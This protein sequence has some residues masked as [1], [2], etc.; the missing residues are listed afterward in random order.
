MA[1]IQEFSQDT[2]FTNPELPTDTLSSKQ[3]NTLVEVVGEGE[4][5][6]S[7]TASKAGLT[8]GT[9]AYN[10]CFK[11]DI[12]LNGTQLLLSSAS[13]TAPAEGDFNF[14][15]VGFE[16]R[17]GTSDQTFINGIANIETETSVGVA[18]TFGNPI[19]RAVSNNSVNAIRVTVSFTNIQKVEDNGEITGAS[20]GVKIEIIQND[21]T[22]TTPIDDTVTGRSTSSYF[23]DYLINLPANTSFPINVRVSRTTADTTSPEFTAFSWSSMTEVIFKQNAYPDTAHLALRFSAESFPRIPKRSFRLRGIKTKI[24]HNATVDIATGRITYTGT[25]NGT[26]KTD[27]EWHSDPAWVLWDILTNTRYGLSVAE[28]SLDQYTFYNQSVY[29]NELVDDGEG[30]QEARFAINV[31]ITQQREAFNLINDICSVMRVMPF[32]AAG[33][34][35]ISG[36]RPSDPVYQFTLANVTEEGFSYSGSSLKTRHTVI[37]VGYFDLETRAIDYETVEDTAAIAKYGTVIKTIKT[38]GCTSRGQAS[39]MGKWFLYNEQKSGES[40]TFKITPE[41]GTL[42]RCGQIISISDPVK[43]GLRRGGKIKSATTTAIVVDDS[44]NTD[45]DATNNAT[46]SVILPDGSLETKTISSI[47]GTIINVSSAFSAAPNP[48]SVFVIQND[49]LETT[50]WRVITVKENSDFT[51][52]VTALAHDSAKY[53]FVEDGVALPTRT[54]TVLTSIKDAPSNLEAE[55]K[56]VVID[57]KA[58]SK[59]FLNWQPVLGVNKYQVQYRFNNGN[60]ITQ[61]VMSNTFDI[62]NSQKGIYEVRVFSFNAIDKPSAEPAIIT[63]NAL[64]KTALPED[65]Q[66][67]TIEPYNDDF[68]KLRFDKATSL[69]VVHGGSV[70]VRHSNLTDG[71]GTFTNSVDLIA[72]L[73]GNISETLIPAIEGEVIL[74]FRDDGGRLSNGETSVIVSPPN[75]QPTLA[76]FTDRED[77]D[78]PPFG[79]AKVNTFFD[80]TLGALTLAS[81]TTIDEVTALIDTLSQIDFLGDV[82]PTGT[83]EFA[84]PL[85]LGSTMDTKLTRH[86]VTESIYANSFIDQR[87]ALI[88]TWND[89]DQL[90]AFETNANLLVATTTQD[91]AL[92]TSGT[93]AQSGTTITITKSS[94]GYSVG[95]FVVVDF[96]SGNG[97]DGNYEIKTVPNANTF[98]LTASAS[99]TTSGN[100]TYG[101]EFGSFNTFTNGVLRGRGFK[102]KVNLSSN[103]PAQTILIKQLGYTATLNRRVETVNSVIASGTST[104]AVTFQDKFFTGFSGTDVA[105][106]AAKPTI[107]IVIENA[108]SGDFFSLSSIS[109]TGF[110]IDIKNGSS[111]VD[112]NFKYTAVG[113][114]RGS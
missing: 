4:I 15:D 57:N 113:F 10:T 61:N 48:N 99:Q 44:T 62:E 58:V 13:N 22:T 114:G 104:K 46:L 78:S 54:T 75:T 53:A 29:N 56:I 84:N 34:I 112:R 26:F 69:D 67:L 100:C 6:G 68:V 39:R 90:T 16:P 108:Q 55:E 66:N 97:V 32:Y 109:S 96:T 28:S 111:F 74:K 89:I 88:D 7:A 93:Y 107:G 73:S 63:V 105:A 85:D 38:F 64:G 79:G 8:K 60:F 19:T 71:T 27:K 94:H 14:K 31:N 12:F 36:D 65:V 81:T 18:V 80:S 20:A 33:S 92:S 37:N 95:S 87:T 35:S 42:V 30:G 102:F 50:T 49:T 101:A 45:L 77:T 59:I 70:V 51:F 86:F 82:A 43:A 3:F 103:D 40:C 110:S 52:D 98:T 72:A 76:A 23:R 47:S 9:T 24:P 17:F 106:D 21:G 5:E 41:S 11:K 1:G 25:F 83:Y 91:P 2:V